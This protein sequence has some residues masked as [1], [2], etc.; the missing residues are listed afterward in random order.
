MILSVSRRTDIPAFYG[1]WFMN[2]V[3]AGDVYVRNPFNCHQVSRI[4]IKPEIVEC[5]VFWTKNPAPLLPHLDEIDRLYHSGFYFQYT[6][7]GYG[8]ELEPHVPALEK[9]IE[10]LQTIS[11]RYGKEHVVWRYDPILL[12]EEYTIQW[13]IH[14]FE[15]IF[16]QV[17]DYTD[18]C[19]ISFV[20]LYQKT[21]N[22]TKDLGIRELKA[23]EKEQLAEAFSRIVRGSGVTIRTCAEGIDL[24]RYGIEP[25]S[26]ID[27]VRIENLIGYELTVNRDGQRKDCQCIECADIGEYDTCLHDCKYCYANLNNE[28]AKQA[29]CRHDPTSPLLIGDYD[30]QQDRLTPYKKAKPLPKRPKTVGFLI[31]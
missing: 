11:R 6:V 23:E 13:H 7:N 15:E 4:D 22:N 8:R 16:R 10:V 27:R 12:S 5:I 26:C 24:K 2:R 3:R 17:R 31:R 25:N 1:E 29:Y 28:K 18:T 30:A 21:K 20:D 9:R 19:V 14:T